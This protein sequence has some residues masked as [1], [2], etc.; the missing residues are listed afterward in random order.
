MNAPPYDGKTPFRELLALGRRNLALA[1]QMAAG[2]GRKLVVEIHMGTIAC[3]PSLA[4]QLVEGSDPRQV[5]LIYDP[6]N[7]AVE[8]SENHRLGL[9]LVAD[10][11]A[12]VHVKNVAW[13]PKPEGG[14]HWKFCPIPDGVVDWKAMMALLKEKN[15]RGL[16]SFEDFGPLPSAEK[17]STNLPYIKACLEP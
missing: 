17:L 3:S 11:L 12:A 8:G 9:D 2:H 16:V 14:W 13:F 7:M 4:L 1:A 15:Y 6:A 10:Y 5:G